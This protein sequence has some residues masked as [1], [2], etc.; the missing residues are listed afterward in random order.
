MEKHLLFYGS[1]LKA[2]A[3]PTRTANKPNQIISGGRRLTNQIKLKKTIKQNKAKQ[4][5]TK[6]NNIYI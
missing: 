2:D 1:R 6:H 3:C 4:N 5:I